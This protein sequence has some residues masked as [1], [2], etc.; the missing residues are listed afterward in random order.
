V[1]T[2]DGY[3]F[4]CTAFII[5][6]TD[7]CYFNRIIAANFSLSKQRSTIYTP[8]YEI[9]TTTSNAGLEINFPD[10]PLDTRLK[11]QGKTTNGPV[12]ASLHPAFEVF[13]K[14]LTTGREAPTV[15]HRPGIEDPTG[16]NRTRVVTGDRIDNEVSGKVLWGLYP[17]GEVALE[18][19]NG[20]ITLVV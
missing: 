1:G 16:K 10:A 2:T 4:V 14:L 19:T 8:F 9:S 5:S 18:T 12:H 7:Y 3:V 15:E 20:P 17:R 13:Y 11:Y 6:L